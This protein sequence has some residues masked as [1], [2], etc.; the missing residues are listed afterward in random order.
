MISPILFLEEIKN[1]SFKKLQK[2][3]YDEIQFS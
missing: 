1:L 2:E 3:N